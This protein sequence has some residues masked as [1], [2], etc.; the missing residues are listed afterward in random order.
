M[1]RFW[2]TSLVALVLALAFSSGPAAAQSVPTGGNVRILGTWGTIAHNFNPF[3][4]S[5][6][7]AAGTRSV[8]YEPLFFVNVLNGD[9]VPAL[10]ISYEWRD[11]NLKLVVK[12][13]TGV[14][15][16][17][18]TPFS[19][20]D[21]AFT[22]NYMK[23]HPA[24]D[25]LGVWA[26]GLATVKAVGNDT[27]EFTFSKKNTPL[28]QSLVSVLIVPEHV[29][30]KVKDPGTFT[31]PDPIGTG[32]FLLK[33]YNPQ[34]VTYVKNPGY[35]AKGR[36][37]VDQVTYQAVKSN[38]TALL[39]LLRKEADY[40]YLFIP[41]PEKTFAEKDPENNHY[42]WPVTNT[43]ILY[44]NTTKS[45]FSDAAFRR[46]VASAIDKQPLSEK[47]YYGAAAPADP[48]AIV[49]GQQPK[50]LDKSAKASAYSYDAKQARQILKNAGYS[51]DASGSLVGPKGERIPALKILVGAGWTDFISM[52]QLIS[53]N[54]KE[55]GLE[56]VIDQE[57]W[58]AYIS[59]LMSGT[60]DTA[61]CWGTG[62]GST[63]YELYYRTLASEF[64]G[65]DGGEA[66]SN[67]ARF[68]D[69]TIDEA[70]AAFRASSDFQ[71]QR[72]ALAKIQ[73]V[74]VTEV[75]FIPLTNRTQFNAFQSEQFEG[76]PSDDNPYTGGDAAD[77]LGGRLM[78]IEL[79]LKK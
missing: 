10:G 7:N 29:W 71:V 59:S 23:E 18:G 62:S 46:A 28:F 67:Y 75:P 8:L 55:I 35:W 36:P 15:W 47:A 65:L 38:D 51:W 27:C 32:P 53:Q 42:W 40:S 1:R 41:D 61:I 56:M 9:V 60:Y 50:W 66:K 5:G 13:R 58:N 24:Q 54:L 72:E 14:E 74:I 43:N 39:L 79:H 73:K 3:V 48:T 49:P 34:A 25:L 26:N 76:W 30:S 11:N 37:Y 52:A 17:D 19:A 12:T 6:Q 45:P 44:M 2:G 70:L 64:A 16:S 20:K 63:P 33:W 4:A 77:E 57:P 21:V 78:L 69:P 22:F 31:N 68:V